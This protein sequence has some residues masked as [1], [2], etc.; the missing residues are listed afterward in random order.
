M[1]PPSTHGPGFILT[2][3][4]RKG[5][6]GRSTLL[7]NLAGA[8]S[9][10]AGSSVGRRVLIV[11]LDPQASITQICLGPEA[12]DTIP[13]LRSVVGLLS[14]DFLDAPESLIVPSGLAGI[15]LIPG[16]NGLSRYNFPDPESTGDLQEALRESLRPLR[17]QYDVILCDTP[18]SL[19]TLAWLPAV[20]ADVAVTPTPAEPLAVQEL[21]HAARFLER[22]RWARNPRLSW[23]GVVLTLYQPRLAVH[24]AYAKAL[25][26]THGA[27]VLEPTMP[28]NVAFKECMVAR[29]PLA[30]WKPRTAAAKA[31]DAIAVEILRRVDLLRGQG[32][33]Q[34]QGQTEP[35]PTPT[36]E[37]SSDSQTSPSNPVSNLETL[38][39]TAA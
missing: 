20:A 34:G 2:A 10:P 1:P 17:S 7:F 4:Q 11:D 12:V 32:Q 26:E 36:G 25:R 24:A 29:K 18:P 15:D 23:L 38:R 27:L 14:D 3:C 6:V 19:E 16:S 35:T 37:T 33:A 21:T 30:H 13:T 31:M 5:G 39:E 22:A 8:L 28:F 9:R